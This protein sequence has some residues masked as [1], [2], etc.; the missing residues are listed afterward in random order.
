MK[1][2]DLNLP[3]TATLPGTP[4]RLMREAYAYT[5]EAHIRARIHEAAGL[6]KRKPTDVER[7]LV[8]EALLA[9]KVIKEDPLQVA[10]RW[11]QQLIDKTRISGRLMTDQ[12]FEDWQK[13]RDLKVGDRVQFVGPT[14]V[15]RVTDLLNIE[16]S[17]GQV[18]TVISV[19]KTGLITVAPIEPV[20]I[21]EDRH[22]INLQVR[23]NTKGWLDL[24]RIP[25]VLKR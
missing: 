2:E 24:E 18:L 8:G 7:E 3:M 13:H 17:N 21:G 10:E 4:L 9:A 22:F 19:D 11:V 23:I 1:K 14:R 20:M 25:E 16:R 6:P 5:T 15:E 12:Q